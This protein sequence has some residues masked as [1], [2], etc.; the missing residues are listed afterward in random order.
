[1]NGSNQ[2]YTPPEYLRTGL[3]YGGYSARPGSRNGLSSLFPPPA[4]GPLVSLQHIDMLSK[5][6]IGASYSII[7]FQEHIRSVFFHMKQDRRG[8][9]P[10]PRLL[11]GVSNP[12]GFLGIS[13]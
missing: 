10:D 2:N 6:V 8:G 7:Y 4:V 1:M 9:D 3:D 5:K 12:G 13:R 11:F